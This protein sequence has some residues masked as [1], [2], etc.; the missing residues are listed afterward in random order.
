MTLYEYEQEVER[1]SELQYEETL[2]TDEELNPKRINHMKTIKDICRNI[3]GP[4]NYKEDTKEF[5]E[6]VYKEFGVDLERANG[7]YL[8]HGSATVPKLMS[9]IRRIQIVKKD[10]ARRV[11]KVEDKRAE[12]A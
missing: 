9:V 6:K 2:Y 10:I 1:V 7:M 8:L 5:V 12:T 3:I 4:M 11:K